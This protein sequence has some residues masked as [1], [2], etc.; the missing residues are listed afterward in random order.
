MGGLMRLI[1]KVL[2]YL[3]ICL[4]TLIVAG[5]TW[6]VF[7][8]YILQDPSSVT[9]ELSR[10]LLIWIGLFG[11]AYAYRTGSHLGLDIISNRMKGVALKLNRIF[12]HLSVMT[13]AVVVMVIGG[14]SLVSL[15]MTPAQISASLEIKMGFIY[16]AVPASGV[17]ITLFAIDNL[18]KTLTNQEP[19][20]E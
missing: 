6:Q 12:I 10:F 17:L 1:E 14:I 11:A 4:T 3:L 15:T 9:E 16:L 13:F 5:V 7:S 19:A 8:R 20:G 2:A 18:I